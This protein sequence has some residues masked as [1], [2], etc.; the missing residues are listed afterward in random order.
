LAPRWLDL[1]LRALDSDPRNGLA[2]PSTNFAWNEQGA[3]PNA[4]GEI[5]S[6][7]REA[8]AKFGDQ[9]RTLEPLF[10]LAD[11]CYAVRREVIDAIGAGRRALFAGPCWE[12]DYNIRA[13]RAGWRGVWACASYV[14]RPPFS[15]RRRAEETRHFQQTSVCIRTNSAARVCGSR[16]RTIEIIAAAMLART[17]HR[18][19]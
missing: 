15:P 17:S 11:F 7:A 18:L 9:V 3:F 8:E 4:G 19:I 2:G 12:M 13:A 5:E 1:L 14:Y 16:S 10:S 6:T